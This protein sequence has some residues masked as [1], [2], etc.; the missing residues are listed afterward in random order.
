MK[1][2]R[3]Y[4]LFLGTINRECSNM[5]YRTN[6]GMKVDFPLIAYL[7]SDGDKKI[8]F[9]TGAFVPQG[10][11]VP[12]GQPNGP[13]I[14]T[15]EQRIDR[16]LEKIGVA[17]EEIK[18]VVLSHLHW[19]HAGSCH[20]F[21]QAEFIVQKT[22]YNYALNPIK[23]HQFPYRKNEFSDLNFRF[24]DGDTDLEDGLRLI[25][26]PGH[27]PGSQTLLVNTVD[28]IY[29]LVSDLVNTRECWESNP[30]L[31]NG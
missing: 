27:T 31:A 12:D 29:A 19:D 8:L 10:G 16:A 17:C 22:E 26:T 20:F 9:D 30:K 11:F 14:Q 21:K 13:Y 23:I 24:I 6:P 25:L 3:I 4:P 28:G 7:V 18:T 1:Q 2:Y 15:S 5:I